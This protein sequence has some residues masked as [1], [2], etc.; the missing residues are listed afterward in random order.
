MILKMFIYISGSPTKGKNEGTT[1]NNIYEMKSVFGFEK[2]SGR[3]KC[4]DCVCVNLWDRDK[5][6]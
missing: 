4:A 6:A 1:T 2:W 5:Y 3:K